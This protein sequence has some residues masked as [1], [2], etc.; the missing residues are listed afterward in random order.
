[1]KLLLVHDARVWTVPTQLFEDNGWSVIKASDA[2][3]AACQVPFVAP[4]LILIDFDISD[5]VGVEACRLLRA[6]SKTPIIG[7]SRDI[8][9]ANAVAA[10]D[11]GANDYVRKPIGESELLARMN[12]WCR[13]EP[14]RTPQPD[15]FFQCGSLAIDFHLRR[16]TVSDGVIHLRPR[17]YELLCYMVAHA[18]QVLTHKQILSQVWR[19]DYS[20]DGHTLR[21]HV[22]SLRN[23]IESD[24]ARPRMLITLTRIGYRFQTEEPLPRSETA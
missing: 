5:I 22:A 2:R 21:V 14:K 7:V 16:V 17:E 12:V 15:R 19:S 11:A 20:D 6:R 18:N 13:R 23:K 1:M 3:D 9:E 24:P 4:D 10:F 8:E